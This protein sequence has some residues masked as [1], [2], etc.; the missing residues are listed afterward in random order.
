MSQEG[1]DDHFFGEGIDVFQRL[2]LQP[3]K[4]SQGAKRPKTSRGDQKSTADSNIYDALA[5][6]RVPGEAISL[7]IFPENMLLRSVELP[8]ESKLWLKICRLRPLIIIRRVLW[9]GF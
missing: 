7:C 6:R 3:R 2:T 4:A 9:G 5:F 1:R 8:F